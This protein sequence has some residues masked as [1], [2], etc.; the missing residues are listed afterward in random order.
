MWGKVCLFLACVLLLA[1]TWLHKPARIEADVGVATTSGSA[2]WTDTPPRAMPV[3][4]IRA[5]R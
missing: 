1:L 2:G 3:D 4:F 5:G